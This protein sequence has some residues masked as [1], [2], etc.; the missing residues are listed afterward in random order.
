[1]CFSVA[2][3]GRNFVKYDTG[4]LNAN[5]CRETP[6][7]V[8]IGQKYQ[9]FYSNTPMY[10]DIDSIIKYLVTQQ[11]KRNPLLHFLWKAERFYIVDSTCTSKTVQR[12]IIALP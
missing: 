7:L 10:D 9:A 5:I 8:K 3:T 1:M 12:E 4:V 2:P 6:D 11:R